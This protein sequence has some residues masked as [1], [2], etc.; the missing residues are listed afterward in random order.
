MF[1]LMTRSRK[2]A[3]AALALVIGT[4]AAIYTAEV[5]FRQALLVPLVPESDS[6]FR[7]IVAEQ[8][9]KPVAR[10]KRPGTV[11]ILGLA[12]SFGVAGGASN[13]HYRLEEILRERGYDVEVVNLSVPAYSLEHELALLKRFGA[14]Y[15]PD[16]V[17]HGFFVGNDFGLGEPPSLRYRGLDIKMMDGPASWLPHNLALARWLPKW[18]RVRAEQRRQ[19]A[20]REQG[21][22]EGSFSRATFL[23]IE[24]VRFGACR[25]P[26]SD[27]PAWLGT[28]A[29][30]DGLRQAVRELNAGHLLV[31]HPDQFQVEPTLAQEIVNTFGLDQR[32]YDLDLPQK[33]LHAYAFSRGVPL[34]DLTPAFRER[35]SAGGLYIPRD[36]HYN[37]A[38]NDLAAETLADALEPVVAKIL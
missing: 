32:E 5:V 8:W 36:S 16:L 6:D 7:K 24:R 2:T 12:D 25:L 30:L 4:T 18:S 26:K 15:E 34:V 27:G 17:L 9:P 37:Q 23:D 14:R 3:F 22:G 21:L 31:V 33:F 11:R 35:G 13:Y 1:A 10:S 20:D 28:T 38:G 29:V 19:A